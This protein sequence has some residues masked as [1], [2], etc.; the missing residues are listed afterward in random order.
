MTPERDLPPVI[1][2]VDP[3]E[4]ES[5]IQRID[6]TRGSGYVLLIDTQS[7]Q[8]QIVPRSALRIVSPDVERR[9]GELAEQWY[10]DTLLTSSY[11]D[12]ILHPAYQK[13][14]RLDT[15]A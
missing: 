2:R 6:P 9:F 5:R 10:M 14:L 4:P 8:P 1:G 3:A 7:Q 11:F 13:I 12:K 15:A